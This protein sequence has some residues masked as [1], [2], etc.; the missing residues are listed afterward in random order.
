MLD[1]SR[2][3]LSVN[4]GEGLRLSEIRVIR[5]DGE[6]LNQEEINDLLEE[7]ENLFPNEIFRINHQTLP[8]EDILIYMFM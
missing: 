2:Y 4:Q 3:R 5:V 1:K 6:S 7:F 8:E